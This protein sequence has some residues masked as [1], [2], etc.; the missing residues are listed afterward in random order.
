MFVFTFKTEDKFVH[1]EKVNGSVH[2]KTISSV[3]VFITFLTQGIYR[4]KRTSLS[5][6]CKSYFVFR[7]SQFQTLPRRADI[8]RF[9]VFFPLS[10]RTRTFD[11]TSAATTIRRHRLWAIVNVVKEVN[12]MGITGRGVFILLEPN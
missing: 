7:G 1:L 5:N 6:G 11:I 8:L 12:G 2:E 10:L 9:F 4:N 3:Y